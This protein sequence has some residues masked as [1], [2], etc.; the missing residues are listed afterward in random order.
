MLVT[1][2]E[3][4]EDARLHHY[5]IPAFDVS[6]YEMMKAVLVACEE[7]GSPALLMGLGV[8]CVVKEVNTS[9]DK[10]KVIAQS[11]KEGEFV[12]KGSTVEISVSTGIESEG[13][14]EILIPIPEEATGK[15]KIEVYDPNANIAATSTI[16]K[17]EL[18]AGG[19]KS[20]SVSGTGKGKYTVYVTNLSTSSDDIK[21]AV[22]EVDFTAKKATEE[23]VDKDAFLS[24]LDLRIEVPKFT[25]MTYDEVVAQYGES[26]TFTKV[27][28]YNAAPAGEVYAQNQ[29]AGSKVDKGANITLNVSIGPEPQ[30]TEPP[31]TTD[32]PESSTTPPEVTDPPVVSDEVTA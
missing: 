29:T 28:G 3:M 16:D 11:V 17:S 30:Q 6:N 26:F 4:L 10:G 20:V 22:Y 27:E 31:V 24:I 13:S 25:G 19:T 21:Y 14:V 9:E 1:M 5:A 7:E 15:F 18:V 12:Q 32:P 23:S 2:K 8:E